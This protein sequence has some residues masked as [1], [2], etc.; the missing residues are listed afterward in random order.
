MAE[1]KTIELSVK[2]MT[3]EGCVAAVTRIVKKADPQADVKIEL[4]SGKVA[5][6]SGVDASILTAAIA[7]GGYEAQPR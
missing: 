1:N 7:K 2:G 3:C 6:Q 4:A 5:I